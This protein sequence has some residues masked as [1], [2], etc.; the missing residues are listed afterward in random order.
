MDNALEFINALFELSIRLF[1]RTQEKKAGKKSMNPYAANIGYIRL[2]A[3]GALRWAIK[4]GNS[5]KTRI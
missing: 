4:Y 5:P 2:E 3:I 1:R